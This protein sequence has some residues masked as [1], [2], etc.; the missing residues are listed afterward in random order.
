VTKKAKRRS[1]DA[2]GDASLVSV[3]RVCF[4]GNQPEGA[5]HLSPSAFDRGQL[6][7]G[8]GQV[9]PGQRWVV[10]TQQPLA[11]QV[12]LALDRFVVDAQQAAVGAAEVAA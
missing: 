7:V 3:C 5:L 12:R 4:C 9:F 11:A 8:R 6:L 10:G 2:G 1:T